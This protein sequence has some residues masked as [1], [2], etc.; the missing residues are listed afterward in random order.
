MAQEAHLSNRL[1]QQLAEIHREI[2]EI[3]FGLY[4]IAG[5]DRQ[6]IE[7]SLDAGYF[8]IPSE[9]CMV[10]EEAED[11]EIRGKSGQEE[12]DYIIDL[13]SYSLGCLLGRWDLR[14][15]TGECQPPEVPDPFAPLPVCSPGMLQGLDGLPR[16]ETPPGYPLCINWAGILVDD[17]GHPDDIMCRIRDVLELIWED[18]AEAA[19]HEAY[20]LLGVKSLR[21]YIARPHGFFADHLKRYSKSRRKAPIYWPLSTTSGSYTVWLYYHRLTDQT[22]YTIVNHYV[23]PK[24]EDVQRAMIRTEEA[25]PNAS[26]AD[27]TRLRDALHEHRKFLGELQDMKQE[28][29]RVAAL[30][31]KP[32]LNDG[33]IINAAPLFT[34]SSN[35]VPGRKTVQIAGRSWKRGTT[36]GRTWP[37]LSGYRPRIRRPLRSAATLERKRPV[38]GR[39]VLWGRNRRH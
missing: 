11:E 16:R 38:R 31:Y 14:F 32:D 21:D 27:S 24:I 29:L 19:E 18:R 22:L 9:D 36:T 7:D 23:E 35:I 15:A 39:R 8:Q 5:S 10:D 12:Q 20:D 28:L 17:S 6:M 30:P 2:N 1:R 37:T 33:V 25:L 3:A 34:H 26:G 13:L 4:G